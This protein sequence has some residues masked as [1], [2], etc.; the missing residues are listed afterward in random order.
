MTIARRLMILLAV[1][2]LILVV[3]GVFVRIQLTQ[4]DEQSR[5]LAEMQIASVGEVGT[6]TRSFS[7]MRINVRSFVLAT[8]AAHQAEARVRFDEDRATLAASLERYGRELISDDRDRQLYNDYRSLSGQWLESADACL[9]AAAAGRRDEAIDLVENRM[10]DIG[11]KLSIVSTNWS[12]HNQRLAQSAGTAA[13]VAIRD[14]QR[15]ALIAVLGGLVISAAFGFV[16][17]RRIV[18]PIRDLKASVESIAGGEYDRDVPF[19]TATDE[20]GELARSIDVLKAGAAAMDEQ[21]WVNAQVARLSGSLQ[22]AATLSE[23]GQRLVSGLVPMLGGGVAGFYW[24]EP[25]AG[26]LRRLADFGLAEAATRSE[27]IA[28]GEGLVGQCARENA[29][30]ALDHLPPDYLA[31]TSG[32]G[33]AAPVQTVAWPIVSQHE[34]LGVLE[35]ASFR[36]FTSAE[37]TLLDELLPLV[38]M[39]LDILA[40]NIRT[41]ELLAQ[42]QEQARQLEEHTEELTQSQHEL[43]EHKEELLAQQEELRTS[44]EQFRTLLESAPDALV[45]SDESGTIQIVNVQA[46]RLFGYSRDEMV[47]QKVEMLLPERLRATHPARREGY[48]SNPSVR[49]MGSGLELLALNKDGVEF[50]VEVSLSPLPETHGGGR[51]V[52]SSLRDISER[53][54]LENEIRATEARTRQILE[55]TAE[56]IFGCDHEGRITFVNPA[57]SEMLGFTPDEL[58]G[59]PSHALFHHHHADGREYPQDMCPMFAAYRHGTSSRIDDE[60]LWRKDGTSVPVEYGATPIRKDGEVVGAV[61]SFSDITERRAAEEE[62]QRSRQLLQSVMDNTDALIYVKGV[63]G[64]YLM[65]NRQLCGT[66]KRDESELLGRL[67]GE[68]FTSDEAARIIE[69]DERIRKAMVPVSFEETLSIDGEEHVFLSNKFPLLDPDGEVIGSAGVSTDITGLKKM[70]AELLIAR[71]AAEEATKAKSMFLANMS[72]EIRTPMNA[73]IGLS[74]LALKTDLNPKQRDYVSKVHNAG[75]SLL[76]I[77]NDILDFSKIEAGKLDIEV[78]P[79][80]V[81]DVISSVTVL[82]AQKAHEKGLEFLADVASDLPAHL[83]GDPLRLGQVLTNLV[84]NAVKFT[85][86]GEI[87]LK[88]EM[89][90]RTEDRVNLKFSVRDTG[91]GMTPEQV[92]K[93]FQAFTQADMSTTRKHGGTGLGLTISQ[94]LVELM[95]G[96]IWAESE[97]GVGS[98]FSFTAWFGVGA[99]TGQRKGM[100]D[101]LPRLNV[102]VADDNEAAREILADALAGIVEHVDLVGSGTE[103]VAAVRQHDGGEPYDLVF[104]DWRMPGIDGLQAIQ[105]IKDDGTIHKQ[106][107]MVMVTAFGREEVR[108]EA[109]RLGV[110]GFL[111]KPITKSMLVDTLVRLFADVGHGEARLDAATSESTTLLGGMRILLTEDNEINQQIAVELLEGVGAAVVVANNGREA[112]ERLDREPTSFDVVLMDLQMPEMDGYQA[113]RKIRSDGRFAELPIIAMTAHA[114]TEEKQSCLAAG[115]NDHVSKPIDPPTLYGTLLKYHSHDAAPAAVQPEPVA[116]AVPAASSAGDD[117]F[118]SIAGLDPVDGLK[119]VAGNARL[120]RKLLLESRE[121][122]RSACDRMRSHLA[123]GERAEAVRLAHTIKGVAGNL[124]AGRVQTAGGALEAALKVEPSGDVEP[125]IHA[126]G[127][128][129]AELL[130]GL[131][132]LDTS[133]TS[134]APVPVAAIDPAVVTPVIRELM[135]R[136]KSDDMAAESTLNQL[137]ELLGANASP[138]V[139]LIRACVDDLEFADA[140]EPLRRMAES[141]G[142]ST[143]A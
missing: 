42:T 30:V 71:D 12:E 81:D 9:A 24:L 69:N 47:G 110:D 111:T 37:S 108:E 107:A 125:L 11:G 124:G 43:L 62:S 89:I 65:V 132:L 4:I 5:F 119:R 114:T 75:T 133:A 94:L 139:A 74:H 25:D 55:S 131:D 28:V 60:V 135:Q 10:L 122:F 134:A 116:P 15:N 130:P 50:P 123:N 17:F 104:M 1:P 90:E 88:I 100:T 23:F 95:E 80:D 44:E 93:L 18:Y 109:E 46:E 32:L 97:S 19:T 34:L 86:R 102:L 91:L 103:A 126:L 98:T 3:L 54:R 51:L 73:I 22:G 141:L 117:G 29:R 83:R 20:T 2:L 57:V 99:E 87:R 59:Q 7:E 33:T 61:V 16:T 115:M 26:R 79:F 105:R 72:H 36:T 45:I 76:A 13:V 53:K 85:E 70:E 143:D 35:F 96:K 129:V 38:G 112:V 68:V 64:R 31:I 136:L 52:C 56:G 27:T 58:L 118:G 63:D 41:Q 14:A 39:S 127:D 78:I 137:E 82:T 128:A 48:H 40:R 66:L 142:I 121:E 6:I 120:Y 140:I 84:N 106:P 92:N 67:P 49:G 8:N 101:R 138:D 113:T 77:L 21:R